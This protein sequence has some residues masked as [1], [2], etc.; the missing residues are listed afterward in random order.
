MKRKTHSTPIRLL[1]HE[2][3]VITCVAIVASSCGGNSNN[4]EPLERADPDFPEPSASDLE[5]PVLQAESPVS[6]PLQ[7]D[8]NSAASQYPLDI[9]KDDRPGLI[10]TGVNAEAIQ[11]LVS[12]FLLSAS[13]F[14]LERQTPG[15]GDGYV[16]M[17]VYEEGIPV[18][19]H[20]EFYQPPIES[21]LLRDLDHDESDLND[22]L[23]SSASG[24]V[25]V[26]VN[27]PSGPWFTF[28][29]QRRES[30][31]FVYQVDNEIPGRI[32]ADA[33]LSVPGDT[34]PN[35]SAHPI[36]A[37]DTP[38][39]LL[40]IKGQAVTPNSEFSWV[41]GQE[42]GYIKINLLVYDDSDEFLGFAVTCWAE[43]DGQFE[44]PATVVD[45]VLRSKFTHRARY[46]RVYAR[47]VWVNGMVIHQDIEVAE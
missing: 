22:G 16:H 45:Y 47:L 8:S 46:S 26:V 36:F 15:S 29:R 2:L 10:I 34:F 13:A 25:G 21:C 41:A 6:R 37:P 31:E 14:R 39:R 7:A 32:P 40:P 23:H 24:G 33:T 20:I 30:G 43:D 19:A 5:V 12:P 17:V 9:E 3:L 35:V 38:V 1:L 18:S 11:S 28:D 42:N 4:T 27:S 44:M